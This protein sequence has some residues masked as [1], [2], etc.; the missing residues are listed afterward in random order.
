MTESLKIIAWRIGLILLLT[1]AAA[2]LTGCSALSDKAVAIAS[3]GTAI[4]VETT[5]S[6]SSGTISP[7][8]LLGTVQNSIATA[9]ALD[10]DKSTQ[11]SVAY[12]ES[13]SFF[14]SL[15]GIDAKTRTFSYIGLPAEDAAQ[16]KARLEAVAS[17]LTA[18]R[19]KENDTKGGDENGE[20]QK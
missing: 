1:L 2:S 16:T 7:N 15:F 6:T 18:T 14:G 3:N 11:I 8:L 9:P 19:E 20:V 13:G 5:G 17:V 12:T 10:Q 4:R